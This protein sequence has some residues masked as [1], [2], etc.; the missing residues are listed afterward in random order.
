MTPSPSFALP[1]RKFLGVAGAGLAASAVGLSRGWAAANTSSKPDILVLMTDQWNPRNLGYERDPDVHT[2]NLDALAAQSLNF[3]RCY[4]NCPICMPARGC[5][6]SG[7]FPHN[8]GL[9]G[10]TTEYY[11]APGL[12][13]LFTELRGAGYGTAQIGKFHWLAGDGYKREFDSLSNYYKAVGLEHAEPIDPPFS[14]STSP[15]GVYQDYL[16]SLGLYE[17]FRAD[18]MARLQANQYEPKSTSLPAERHNDWFTADRAIAYLN[19]RPKDRPYFLVTSFP[20]PHVP[21]DA[22]RPYTDRYDPA[23]LT[24]P[25]N[26]KAGSIGGYA[27]SMDDL[28]KMRANYLAKM[29]LIDDCVGRIVRTLQD[30]GTWDRTIV[31]F[32]ADH[33]DMMGAQG[34]VSKTVFFEESARVPML[35]RVPGSPSAGQRSEAPVQFSDVYATVAEAA[36]GKKNP[37]NFSRSML[38]MARGSSEHSR[39][40]AFSEISHD[41]DLEF[42]VR[43]KRFKWF[44]Q[45]R[46]S[47]LFDL[48][49]DPYELNN[50]AESRDHRGVIVDCKDRL[51]D[52]LMTTQINYASGYQSL[53]ARVKSGQKISPQL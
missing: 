32:T 9:W 26:A 46:R 43:D 25:P 11:L 37:R 53:G 36:G 52:F 40:T 47:Y 12:A 22:M 48:Q 19:E 13:T 49:E 33:G 18:M 7:L 1:R 15:K 29:T 20:G 10:N 30:R 45:F 41:S 38:S 4:S 17:E 35:V 6:V 28:R 16:R 2:P 8:T 24:L 27:F 5:F 14:A 23:H 42:M 50:L 3:A 44:H 21:L 34:R 39:E 31:I 51:R